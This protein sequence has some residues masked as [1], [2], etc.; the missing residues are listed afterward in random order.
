MRIPA[1]GMHAAQVLVA[2]HA[3]NIANAH[4]E[5]YGADLASDVVG[6][7]IAKHAY[8]ANAR[9]LATMAETE[10]SLLDVLA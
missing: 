7:M 3:H 6:V 9:A 2:V 10:R 1:S 5:D 4:T 8:T